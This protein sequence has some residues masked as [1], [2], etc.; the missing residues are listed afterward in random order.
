[1][2]IY[3]Y[4]CGDCTKQFELLVLS[5]TVIACPHCESRKLEQLLSGF[6]VSSAG[7]RNTNLQTARRQISGSTSYRDQ[8]KAEGE[9]YT[10]AVKEHDH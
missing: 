6:A 8:K 1:M 10:R 9:S 5:S 3:E 7:T 4:Q 2:P